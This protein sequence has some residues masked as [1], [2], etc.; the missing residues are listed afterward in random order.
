MMTM[1]TSTDGIGW[2]RF[3]ST[4]EVSGF[5]HNTFGE[6]IGLRL[7]IYAAGNGEAEFS[8]FRYRRIE[9]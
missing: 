9:E 5:N 1:F 2:T 3:P 7:G 8:R 4:M 6:F